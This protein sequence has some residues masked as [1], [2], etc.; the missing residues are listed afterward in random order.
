MDKFFN[1]PASPIADISTR[2]FEGILRSKT[3]I[4]SNIRFAS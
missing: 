4:Q 2:I 1:S 3:N